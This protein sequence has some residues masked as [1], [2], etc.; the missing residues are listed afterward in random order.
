MGSSEVAAIM[1]L[2]PYKTKWQIWAEK[3]GLIKETGPS[4]YAMQRGIENEGKARAHVEL[5]LGKEFPPQLKT[6]PEFEFMRVSLDGFDGEAVLEIKVPSKQVYE[7]CIK[8]LVPA[9][10]MRQIQYQLMVTGASYAIFACY[11]VELDRVAT[12]Q[13]AHD[14]VMQEEIKKAVTEFW[15]TNVLKNEEPEL[16]DRDTLKIADSEIL[17]EAEAYELLKKEIIQMTARKES[18]EKHL[19][20]QLDKHPRLS[21]GPLVLTRSYKK[22]SVDYSKIAELGTVDLEKYRK[23]GTFIDTIRTAKM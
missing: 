4:N 20:Q 23:P 5:T 14:L 13:V 10:Y 19:K 22:G 7:D 1:G 16:S 9:H 3:T 2:C 11:S 18:L 15:Y 17:K 8:G 12:T 6:H 21:I